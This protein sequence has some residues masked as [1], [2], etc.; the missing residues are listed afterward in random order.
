MNTIELD[1]IRDHLRSIITNISEPPN[2]WNL[3]VISGSRY[4][5][6]RPAN[7]GDACKAKARAFFGGSGTRGERFVITGPGHTPWMWADPILGP[8][9]RLKWRNF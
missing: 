4:T 1:N 6:L 7:S 5:A 3:W 2:G 8:A 9:L